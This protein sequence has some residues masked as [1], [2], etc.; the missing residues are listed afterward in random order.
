M[1]T[2]VFIF[3]VWKCC[4]DPAGLLSLEARAR[5]E[6]RDDEE[7]NVGSDSM[8]ERTL[9]DAVSGV[10]GGRSEKA[11]TAELSVTG[12]RSGRSQV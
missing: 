6:G 5:W 4:Y 7:S 9:S 10:R 1:G 2:L 8:S 11:T 12:S 3:L